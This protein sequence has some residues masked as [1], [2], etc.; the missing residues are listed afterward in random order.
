MHSQRT[1]PKQYEP[2]M[3]MFALNF[4]SPRQSIKFGWKDGREEGKVRKQ[5][6]KKGRER[7]GEKEGGRKRKGSSKDK[8]K[9]KKEERK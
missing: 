3:Q 5:G 9:M 7:K 1:N 4:P 6:R 2:A 8:E